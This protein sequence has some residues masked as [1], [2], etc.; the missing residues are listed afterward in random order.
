MRS[1]GQNM[2]SG[3]AK[4]HDS[5]HKIILTMQGFFKMC[6][7]TNFRNVVLWPVGTRELKRVVA[8]LF[9]G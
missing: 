1:S 3:G 4:A 6:A 8:V 9:I 5:L 2:V 7:C